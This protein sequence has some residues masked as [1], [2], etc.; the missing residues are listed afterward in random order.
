MSRNGRNIL[1]LQP[2]SKS[3]RLYLPGSTSKVARNSAILQL[4]NSV[5]IYARDVPV[6]FP[7]EGRPGEAKCA[8]S[9]LG[10]PGITFSVPGSSRVK[11]IKRSLRF[12]RAYLRQ[13]IAVA[14]KEEE[15]RIFRKGTRLSYTQRKVG[16]SGLT[17]YLVSGD[18]IIPSFARWCVTHYQRTLG[19]D[20]RSPELVI[21]Y[22]TL[23]FLKNYSSD[24]VSYSLGTRTRQ[25]P[26]SMPPKGDQVEPD[27]DE[28]KSHHGDAGLPGMASLETEAQYV[29]ELPEPVRAQ[30][31]EEYSRRSF[32][33]IAFGY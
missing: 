3:G 6:S 1:S 22:P 18:R 2:I 19:L 13:L 11:A 10:H 31:R 8:S 9:T 32:G 28:T 30:L 5:G 27:V 24:S 29:T 25:S 23:D 7:I 21:K 26:P 15:F 14:L 4:N 16:D 20:P 17:W 12:A 33:T